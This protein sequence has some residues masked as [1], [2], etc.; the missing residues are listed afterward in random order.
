M[1]QDFFGVCFCNFATTYNTLKIL[2]TQAF[3]G[4]FVK[5]LAQEVYTSGMKRLLAYVFPAV[6]FTNPAYF[7]ALIL[8]IL[9]LGVL[10]A[11]L[12]SY[13]RFSE[14]I[15]GFGLAGGQDTAS[16]LAVLV[17]FIEFLALPF[18]IS[19]RLN[20]RAR[21]LSMIAV[22]AAPAI[23]FILSL[24]LNVSGISSQ[25]NSGLF[26]ATIITPVAP[27]LIAF[28]ALWLWAAVLVVRELPVRALQSPHLIHK[29]G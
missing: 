14:V 7:R 2:K 25:L 10:I 20:R 16:L 26:G 19:M 13:E 3:F 15:Y 4:K 22:I 8:A 5:I 21:Q 18:M 6:F 29:V 1:L 24:W 17:P 27:W 28:S 12:F 23:W 11:Q 9:Y